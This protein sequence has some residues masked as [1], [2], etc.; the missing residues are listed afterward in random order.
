MRHAIVKKILSV[1][2]FTRKSI[3]RCSHIPTSGVADKHLSPVGALY[4]VGMM[5]FVSFPLIGGKCD[6]NQLNH[7]WMSVSQ[8]RLVIGT[9]TLWA[10]CT[11]HY[12]WHMS[13]TIATGTGLSKKKQNSVTDY[14][15]PRHK[16]LQPTLHV[17]KF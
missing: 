15:K 1:G 11:R 3:F 2:M 9:M 8:L 16:M 4:V 10:P 6:T 17:S 5:P 7:W 13:N 12:Y 14:M